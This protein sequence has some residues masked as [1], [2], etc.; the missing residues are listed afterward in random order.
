MAYIL[1]SGNEVIASQVA[2]RTSAGTLAQKIYAEVVTRRGQTWDPDLSGILANEITTIEQVNALM[3]GIRIVN[4][5]YGNYICEVGDLIK[6]L[7]II[8]DALEAFDNATNTNSLC[9]GSCVGLCEGCSSGC[10]TACG[11]ACEGKCLGSCTNG[12][13]SGCKGSCKN[14]CDG[15]TV[16]CKDDCYLTCTGKCVTTCTGTSAGRGGGGR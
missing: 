3:Q 13:G 10:S 11:V 15:C 8:E 6:P 9:N 16:Q 4:P 5:D 2:P 12:C 7:H 14:T 1:Q